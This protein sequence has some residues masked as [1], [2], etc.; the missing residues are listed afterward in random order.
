M[1]I[2]S[3]LWAS[4]RRF[5]LVGQYGDGP[6]PYRRGL[7]FV[8]I[9]PSNFKVEFPIFFLIPLQIIV[10][11]FFSKCSNIRNDVNLNMN[12]TG[13]CIEKTI[14]MTGVFTTGAC[15]YLIAAFFGGTIMGEFISE[16]E[17]DEIGTVLFRHSWN[18]SYAFDCL[19]DDA[20]WLNN[21]DICY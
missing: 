21:D 16:S 18:S 1:H 8:I 20:R 9:S 17:R 12:Q 6:I 11:E 15:S 13:A 3:C 19:F 4:S 5:F 7:Y 14:L 2:F 10:D